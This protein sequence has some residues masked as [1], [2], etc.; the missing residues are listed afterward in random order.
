MNITDLSIHFFRIHSFMF[1]K[2]SVVILKIKLQSLSP[3]LFRHF[4][5]IHISM[6]KVRCSVLS[7]P[8]CSSSPIIYDLVILDLSL[9]LEILIFLPNYYSR[10]VW[11]GESFTCQPVQ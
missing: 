1:G 6:V 5:D 11:Q 7:L 9:C 3:S 2:F 8:W 4:V 10:L